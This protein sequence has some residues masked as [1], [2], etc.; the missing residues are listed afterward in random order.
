MFFLKKKI[1][2]TIIISLLFF[3]SLFQ[4]S[5]VKC[6]QD[7]A[8]K[9]NRLLLVSG[10]TIAA[11]SGTMFILN[12]LWYSKYSHSSFHFFNDS[13]EWLQMDKVGHSFSA[14]Y[15]NN[16]ITNEFLWTGMK[17]NRSVLWGS[18]IAFAAMTG[19]EVFDGFSSKWGASWTDLAANLSGC[20]LY[21]GQELIWKKQIARMKFSYHNTLWP[22]YRPDA[23]GENK[24]QSIIKDYNGQTYWLSCNLRSISGI[25]KIPAWLN[26]AFGYSAEAMCGANNNDNVTFET[27]PPI[28]NRF[29]QYYFSLDADLTM[30]KTKSKVLKGI[31]KAFNC[32]KIPFPTLQFEKQKLSFKPFYF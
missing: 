16:I 27:F 22:K 5:I 26:L 6:Q 14:Y 13:Q 32:I 1:R 25:K 29:R 2:I 11:Y 24:F 30:I 28:Q 4:F 23:L 3:C 15:L 8:I 19:I 7:T 31:F 17:R 9:R 21:S 20:L 18:G 10:S 12:Q